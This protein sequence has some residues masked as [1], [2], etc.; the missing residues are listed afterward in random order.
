MHTRDEYLETVLPYR[1]KAIE[2]MRIALKYEIE[3]QH[4]KKLEIYFDD[5]LSIQG[6]SYVWTTPVIEAGLLH[7]RACL[8]FIGLK[9][10]HKDPLKLKSRTSKRK[11][12]FGIEDWGLAKVSISEAIEPYEGPK[13]E[14][15]KA[16]ASVIHC[17][18]KGIAHT[19]SRQVIVDDDRRLYEIAARGIPALM[20]NY[21]Y[22]RLGIEPPKYRVKTNL[23]K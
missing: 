11:D 13:E 22:T 16:L 18:N 19:T 15:E 17:A 8:E 14:A 5:V 9:E 12:D 6:L 21:F 23:P 4:A 10:D 7:C 1:M 3:W 2:L 20:I